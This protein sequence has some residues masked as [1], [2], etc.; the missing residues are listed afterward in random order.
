MQKKQDH[1]LW[2]LESKQ[3]DHEQVDI[4]D[5]LY[6]KERQFM[7]D[8]T[9]IIVNNIDPK[10][11]SALPPQI[12]NDED[13]V[14][15]YTS[16]FEAVE[17]ENLYEYLKIDIPKEEVEYFIKNAAKEEI[18]SQEK[19]KE[20]ESEKKSKK[21]SKAKGKKKK[22]DN[23]SGEEESGEEDEEEK[24]EE[25]ENEEDEEKKEGEEKKAKKKVKKEKKEKK[26]KK[27]SGEESEEEESEEEEDESEEEESGDED[28]E[29][30]DK[31]KEKEK[32]I[33]Q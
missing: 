30:K 11:K 33:V 8:N 6:E 2:I 15:D 4:G 32:N 7:R 16:F 19:A 10:C 29:K 23:K 20:L 28:A 24:D 14:G 26:E 13:Y 1:I 21:K 17:C 12:F 22:D 31:K 18:I 25:E 9:N 5:P 3:I 27:G